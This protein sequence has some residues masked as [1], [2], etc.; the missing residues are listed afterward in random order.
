[1]PNTT[2]ILH[3]T[4]VNEG[5]QFV[6][7]LLVENGRIA[8]FPTDAECNALKADEVVDAT[9]Q[10]LLP[11]LIDC[12]VHFREPGLTQKA[13]IFHE[14]RA[15]AAGG[16]TTVFDMPNT[17]PQTTTLDAYA[18][19][20]QLF[21]ENCLVNYGIFF[22][23]TNDNIDVL[24]QLDPTDVC[25]IKLFMGSSTGNMLVDQEEALR[26]LF[27]TARLP[28]MTHCEDTAI[29]NANMAA[30]KVAHGDDPD[31]SLHAEIRSAEACF[32]STQLAVSLAKEYGAQLHV[33]HLTTADELQLFDAA[34]TNITAEVCIP[35]LVFTDEDYQTLGARIKCNPA[36]KA[37][38]HRE[39]LRSALM[40]GTVYTIGTDH[41]PHLLSDKQGGAAKAVSGMPMVQ[42]SLVSMLQL[43]NEGVLTIERLVELACHNPAKRFD[44][45]ERGFLREGYKADFV[46]LRPDAPWMLKASDV[47]SKCGWS[48]LE[49]VTFDWKVVSTYCNGAAV[50]SNGEIVEGAPLGEAVMFARS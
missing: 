15:A 33:A 45:A 7:N 3:A 27:Q 26:R 20:K 48:P 29:I 21:A 12:H 40:E 38:S 36:V 47:Q 25:G 9:G 24:Q 14:S 31:V 35:H 37:A 2:L 19:K 42:F 4:I 32:K 5:Q 10:Y 30:A 41:A 49:G 16:V 18:E 1:M 46:L 43:V 50:Y 34:D 22:G 23:A 39:T 44:I 8:A 13:D 6:G 28:I 17:V 11:G